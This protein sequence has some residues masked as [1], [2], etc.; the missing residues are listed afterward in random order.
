MKEQLNNNHH[1]ESQ[2]SEPTTNHGIISRN[3]MR[4][5]RGLLPVATIGALS[6]AAPAF[7]SNIENI[8][9]TPNL[10]NIINVSAL[11]ENNPV[12][13]FSDTEKTSSPI[14]STV[15]NKVGIDQKIQI[16]N[17]PDTNVQMSVVGNSDGKK[18]NSANASFNIDNKMSLGEFGTLQNTATI[19]KNLLTGRNPAI[20]SS[21]FKTPDNKFKAEVNLPVGEAVNASASYRSG[22]FSGNASF[23]NENF[24]GDVSLVDQNNSINNLK[25]EYGN[26]NTKVSGGLEL[27]NTTTTGEYSPTTGNYNVGLKADL[28]PSFSVNASAHNEGNEIGVS[29]TD[30]N[31]ESN[32]FAATL[33]NSVEGTEINATA[34]SDLGTKDMMV[35]LEVKNNPQGTKFEAKA[36]YVG[37]ENLNVSAGVNID[38]EQ[39]ELEAKAS[40]KI[41]PNAT[42]GARWKSDGATEAT[43]KITDNPSPTKTY[44]PNTN[45]TNKLTEK[46]R[47]EHGVFLSDL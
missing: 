14:L 23:Q 29:L 8:S 26:E 13:I 6:F 15:G 25:L 39:T 24:G 11:S 31:N 27:G 44:N 35:G 3:R 10:N 12:K 7:A 47:E 28:N 17:S 18:I 4:G 30:P 41:T 16:I 2:N 42:V 9:S 33:T 37:I 45:L 1:T 22:G 32:K 36:S 40:Y 5:L 46:Y 21:K 20:V 34:D 38:A 43:I 19:Q